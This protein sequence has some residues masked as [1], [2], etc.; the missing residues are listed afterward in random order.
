MT[1]QVRRA[2]RV[3]ARAEERERVALREYRRRRVQRN[4]PSP[5]IDYWTIAIA[6][7]ARWSALH[8]LL[9]SEPDVPEEAVA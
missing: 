4:T 7:R 2:V 8:D 9:A 3:T 5:R 6:A 1:P